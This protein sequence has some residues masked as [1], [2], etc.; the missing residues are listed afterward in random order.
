MLSKIIA[1]LIARRI[2]CLDSS[3]ATEYDLAATV[4]TIAADEADRT[5]M[6]RIP[7]MLRTASDKLRR[8][9]RDAKT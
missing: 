7:D 2:K 3:D 8:K 4:L 1:D 9:A 5:T 6:M